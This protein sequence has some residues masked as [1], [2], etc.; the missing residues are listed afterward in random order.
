MRPAGT[1][2]GLAGGGSAAVV[3]RVVDDGVS[4]PRSRRRRRRCRLVAVARSPA[5][6]PPS[7]PPPALSRGTAWSLRSR[8][9][10]RAAPRRS[11]FSPVREEGE[12]DAVLALDLGERRVP[13]LE[14]EV[15]RP[16][17]EPLPAAVRVQHRRGE[18][19]IAQRQRAL[20]RALPRV[21]RLDVQVAVSPAELAQLVAQEAV[22]PLRLLQRDHRVPLERRERLGTEGGDAD[23]DLRARLQLRCPARSAWAQRGR[24]RA[25][26]S[27]RLAR[28]ARS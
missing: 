26:S 8:C 16:A 9:G 25:T 1:G 21:V 24:W 14:A 3:L 7:A 17:V 27:S 18:A 28:A 5:P 10:R 20:E 2:C 23:V 4:P 13:R 22:L 12:P 19:A 11:P 6:P 15:L